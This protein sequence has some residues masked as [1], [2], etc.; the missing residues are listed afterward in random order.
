MQPQILSMT[1]KFMQPYL[2]S[3]AIPTLR[4]VPRQHRRCDV[5]AKLTAK[6]EPEPGAPA[7]PQRM[8]HDER[9]KAKGGYDWSTR[10]PNHPV[11]FAECDTPHWDDDWALHFDTEAEYVE[12]VAALASFVPFALLPEWCETTTPLRIAAIRKERDMLLN[13]PAFAD[14]VTTGRE[15]PDGK[16]KLAL[17]RCEEDYARTM[18]IYNARWDARGKP[19][20]AGALNAEHMKTINATKH[21][22]PTI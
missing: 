3:K 18:Q 9:R 10:I 17:R 20:A 11:G 1:P 19:G 21:P 13:I 2:P 16:P 7:A 22:C 5:L 12:P 6:V 8:N 4:P 15:C 14:Y